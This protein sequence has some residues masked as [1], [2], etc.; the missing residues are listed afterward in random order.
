MNR[1]LFS[2]FLVATF[3]I[4]AYA[5][6][7]DKKAALGVVNKLFDEM[8]AANAAGI[9]STGTPENQL[10]AI[11]K[12]KDGKTRVDV[13]NGEAFTKFFTKPNSLEELMYAP[14]V[15]V[16]G[17]WAMVWGRYVF[18][19]GDKVS[20]CGINQF[21]LVRTEAGWKIANGASTIDP[22]DCNE[23]EKAMKPTKPVQE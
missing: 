13:I 22:G 20:H 15:E 4:A 3:S 12:L 7:D 11:R 18:F 1:I 5:Q 14:N 9:L 17:N 10:V 2:L 6:T 23:K 16:D 19:V 21:N 8:R